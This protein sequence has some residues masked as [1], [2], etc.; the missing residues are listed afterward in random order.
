[1]WFSSSTCKRCSRAGLL[2]LKKGVEKELLKAHLVI[3]RGLTK[4]DIQY[5]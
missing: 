4:N 1:M 3:L 2:L 5:L